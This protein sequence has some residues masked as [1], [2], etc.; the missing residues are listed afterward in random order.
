MTTKE[1]RVRRLICQFEYS[2]GVSPDL[3]AIAHRV[4]DGVHHRTQS[5]ETDEQFRE[6]VAEEI[7]GQFLEEAGEFTGADAFGFWTEPAPDLDAMRNK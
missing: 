4:A 5:G 7:R 1:T 2:C 3:I 6:R